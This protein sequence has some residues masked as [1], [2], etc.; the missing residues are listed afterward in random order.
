MAKQENRKSRR[1]SRQTYKHKENAICVSLYDPT[2]APLP[3]AAKHA[4]ENALLDV[5]MEHKLLINIATT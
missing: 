5:A 4:A 1:S 3:F 2:G